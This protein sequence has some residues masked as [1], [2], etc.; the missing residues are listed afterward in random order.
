[1]EIKIKKIGYKV[2]TVGWLASGI[3]DESIKINEGISEK[4]SKHGLWMKCGP[5]EGID[6]KTYYKSMVLAIFNPYDL[7]LS[8]HEDA[9]RYEIAPRNGDLWC[10]GDAIG[11]TDACWETITEIAGVWIEHVTTERAKDKKTK[12]AIKFEEVA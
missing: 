10:A 4:N 2:G 11:C 9:H 8:E 7:S 3:A 1:M 6:G 12:I 5:Q